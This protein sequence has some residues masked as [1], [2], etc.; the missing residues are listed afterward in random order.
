MQSYIGCICLAFLQCAFSNVSSNGLPEKMQSNTCCICSTFRRCALPNES[1]TCLYEKIHSC[2]ACICLIF[3][4]VRFQ[5]CPQLVCPRKYM[6]SHLMYLFDYSP[7]CV[8]T[9]LLNMSARE[10]AK[11]HWLH[12]FSFSP[13]CVFKCVLKWSA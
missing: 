11:L 7:L 10:D 4:T 9:C 2:I 3:F 6:K 8:I 1:S 13:Q 5:M 12:L